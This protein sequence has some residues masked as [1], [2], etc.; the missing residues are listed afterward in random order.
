MLTRVSVSGLMVIGSALLAACTGHASEEKVT[1]S[2]APPVKAESA[3]AHMEELDQTYRASGTVRGRHTAVLTSKGTGYVRTLDVRPG[4]AIRAGQILVTLDAH[5]VAASVQR[6]GAGL[7]QARESRSEAMQALIGAEAAARNA[8]TTKERLQK[9]YETGAIPEQ[10][11]DDAKTSYDSAVAL[12]AAARA[13][14]RASDS[15]IDGARAE[16]SETSARLSDAKIL[17]PFAGRVLERKVDPGVLASPGTPLLTVEEEG[18]LHVEVPL[19]ESRASSVALG[20]AAEVF[21]DQRTE[22][23]TITEIVPSVDVA[24]RAFLVK[25]GL[26]DGIAGLRPGTFARVSF[27]VGKKRQLVVPASAVSQ[28]G[29]LDRVFVVEGDHAHA[30]MV[31]PGE[32][33]GPWTPIL[34]G[35]IPGERVLSSPPRDMTD[36]ALVT[37]TP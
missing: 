25:V 26:P 11:L 19:A 32:P 15:R 18:A 6:S 3:V 14:V 37:V 24:S 33:S 12:E 23:G 28:L 34:A 35:L 27:H 20:D 2:A 8:K 1:R 4:D 31:S 22:K 21:L 29:S 17:A 7:E 16:L 13:R 30:R 9:L 5:D 10:A 36:D